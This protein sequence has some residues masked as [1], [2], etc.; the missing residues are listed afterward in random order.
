M[1]LPVLS[2]KIL[3]RKWLMLVKPR[4]ESDKLKIYRSLHA[5]MNLS[6]HDKQYFYNL[7]KGYE[8]EVIFDSLTEKL[9]CESLILNDLQ[10]RSNNSSFQIDSSL[11]QETF[12]LFEIK[13]FGGDYYYQADN[14]YT[15]TG[16]KIQNP[17][18]QLNRCESLLSQLLLKNG[19]NIPIQ[20]WVV[21]VNPHFTLYQAPKDK[22]IIYPSQLD[23]FMKKLNTFSGKV[24]GRAHKLAKLL[25]SLHCDDWRYTD[26]P[27][28]DFERL[29]KGIICKECRS[30]SV[31]ITGR[32]IKCSSCQAE[33]SVESA[34]IRSVH[35]LKLL[36][37]NKKI[38]TNFVQNWCQII[39]TQMRITR[40]LKKNYKSMGYG[41]WSYYE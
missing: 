9:E 18:H 4:T 24:N 35:E 36:F 14:F 29:R 7:Q 6:D 19:Y 37:P 13:H 41:Q 40:V 32:M 28:Y 10:L 8:G 34:I 22:P 5:R 2:T 12:Y 21:F 11:I 25:V 16:V 1:D 15:M 39:E 3:K 30:F 33:E 26:F 38:T 31:S 20:P 23:Q 17:L 27:E